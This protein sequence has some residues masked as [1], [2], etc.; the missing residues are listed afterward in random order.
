MP[1]LKCSVTLSPRYSGSDLEILKHAL[2][3]LFQL[4]FAGSPKKIT[5]PTA[6]EF[7][8]FS[9]AQNADI[10]KMCVGNSTRKRRPLCAK[11]PQKEQRRMLGVFT[12]L[13]GF[14]TEN[15]L[16]NRTLL[17]LLTV[18]YAMT[19]WIVV[20]EALEDSVTDSLLITKMICARIQSEPKILEG[21]ISAY[22]S[23]CFS[24]LRPY[25]R[26]ILASML[27]LFQLYLRDLSFPTIPSD[28]SLVNVI[29]V[30]VACM[31]QYNAKE[32]FKNMEAVIGEIMI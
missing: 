19:L 11:S 17:S 26:T 28:T 12:V 7:L 25:K 23:A 20:Q 29:D 30:G 15:T 4:K 22:I 13:F 32:S 10:L 8:A 1:G 14:E 6:D 27:E 24:T 31:K 16:P 9:T 21:P 18:Q 5:P 3:F 2:Q